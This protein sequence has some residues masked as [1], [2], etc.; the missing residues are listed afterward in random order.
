MVSLA[1]LSSRND[2]Q[3][4]RIREALHGK[5]YMNLQVLA[6]P[7]GGEFEVGVVAYYDKDDGSKGCYSDE[8]VREMVLFVLAHAV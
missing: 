1:R 4:G 6:C 7:A 8:E 3:L 2:P 5:T